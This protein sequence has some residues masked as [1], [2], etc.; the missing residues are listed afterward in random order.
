M[1]CVSDRVKEAYLKEDGKFF[2]CSDLFRGQMRGFSQSLERDGSWANY[3]TDFSPTGA[4]RSI[5]VDT[6]HLVR[7]WFLSLPLET[8]TNFQ[9]IMER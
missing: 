6:K 7:R 8:P 9:K 3:Q 2:L 4:A 5:S 1:H